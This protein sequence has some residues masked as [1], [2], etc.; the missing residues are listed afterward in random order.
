VVMV[1]LRL[2]PNRKARAIIRIGIGRVDILLK[3]NA[4]LLNFY[5]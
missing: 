2:V 4:L 3:F 5:F 1:I